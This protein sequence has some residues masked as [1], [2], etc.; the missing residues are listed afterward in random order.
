MALIAKF[1]PAPKS[2][3]P[4]VSP[5][6]RYAELAGDLMAG[7]LLAQMVFWAA[8]G[9][10]GKSKLKVQKHGHYWIAKTRVEWCRETGLS[11]RQY[12]RAYG[13]LLNRELIASK[14]MRFNGLAMTHVRVLDT[15]WSIRPNRFGPFD[16]LGLVNTSK[17]LTEITYS[18]HLHTSKAG[19]PAEGCSEGLHMP[20]VDDVLKAMDTLL[21][22]SV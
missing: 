7:V 22:F 8:P 13:I 1:V 18:E 4:A 14:V 6:A 11:P 9:R 2:S 10:D 16:H 19:G 15:V 17:P 5:V 21:F 20:N 12:R 3:V